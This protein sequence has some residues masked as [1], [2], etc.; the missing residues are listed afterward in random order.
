MGDSK[1]AEMLSRHAQ[2][3]ET[4]ALLQQSLGGTRRANPLAPADMYQ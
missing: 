1:R 4:Q 2:V 3:T